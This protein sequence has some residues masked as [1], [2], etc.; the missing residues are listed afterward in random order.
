VEQNAPAVSVHVVK[1]RV[2]PET[3][4][5]QPLQYLLVQDVGFALNPL[6]VQGQMHGGMAQGLG[7]GL[8]EAMIYDEAGQLLTGSLMDYALPRSDTTPDLET[9]LVQNPSPYGPFGAR[10]VGEPPIIGGAAAVANAVKA[11]TGVRITSLPIRA[12]TL[13]HEL[14]QLKNKNPRHL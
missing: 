13:W 1:V 7:I 14:R 8:Y 10:G 9:V 12:E 4:Q 6:L 2:D 5:V 3:G 11:A